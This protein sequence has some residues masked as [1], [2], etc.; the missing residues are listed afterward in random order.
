MGHGDVDGL[1]RHPADTSHDRR[2]VVANCA[3][4]L[5]HWLGPGEPDRDHHA[6]AV[7]RAA[8]LDA[9]LGAT[10]Q[11]LDRATPTHKIASARRRRTAVPVEDARLDR[12]ET[13]WRS[14]PEHVAS[15][16]ELRAALDAA[17]RGLPEQQRR[18]W[19]L[20]EVEGLSQAEVAQV[21]HLTPDAVR[22]QLFRARRGLVERMRQW[23]A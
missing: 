21:L 16:S 14:D 20:I 22:G 17:L 12:A 2:H 11:P 7:T 19:V 13:G 1:D 9:G 3:S 4:G 5:G 6:Q 23:R 15:N 8:Q 10:G 18:V